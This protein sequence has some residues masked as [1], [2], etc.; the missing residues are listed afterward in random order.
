M[1]AHAPGA[2]PAGASSSGRPCGPRPLSCIPAL[3]QQGRV[4]AVGTCTGEHESGRGPGAGS[5]AQI[6]ET[7][8]NRTQTGRGQCRFSQE[9]FSHGPRRSR[10]MALRGSIYPQF[11][12]AQTNEV[13]QCT[14]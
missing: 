14:W 13:W 7:G 9:D 12:G 10:A 11:S 3:G 4:A 6:K 5:T 2:R 1:T 8:A